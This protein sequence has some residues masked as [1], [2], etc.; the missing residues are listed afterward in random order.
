MVEERKR[1]SWLGLEEVED[2]LADVWVSR[3]VRE[4]FLVGPARSRPVHTEA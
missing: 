1:L 3:L 2:R 4:P